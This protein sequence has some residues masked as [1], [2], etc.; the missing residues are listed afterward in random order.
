M[1]YAY[2][3]CKRESLCMVKRALNTENQ[4]PTFSRPIQWI[5]LNEKFEYINYTLAE[6]IYRAI[7]IPLNPSDNKGTIALKYN[8][9]KIV[10][11][12]YRNK[13][14]RIEETEQTIRKKMHMGAMNLSHL[15][16]NHTAKKKSIKHTIPR[17]R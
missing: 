12:N 17:D 2:L 4:T 8:V 9:I 13:N 11:E 7:I 3:L 6:E 14:T 16:Q 1:C 15:V 10:L 5:L